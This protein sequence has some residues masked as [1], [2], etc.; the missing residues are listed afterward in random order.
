M[1]L[2]H[3][4][5]TYITIKYIRYNTPGKENTYTYKK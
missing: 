5:K 4:N 3:N 2:F 1:Q